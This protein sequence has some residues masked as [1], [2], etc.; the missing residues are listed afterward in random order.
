MIFNVINVKGFLN[1][2]TRIDL[3]AKGYCEL[4]ISKNLVAEEKYVK[5]MFILYIFLRKNKTELVML[6]YAFKQV[7]RI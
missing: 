2:D 7:I 4:L 3:K 5:I 1:N 6:K